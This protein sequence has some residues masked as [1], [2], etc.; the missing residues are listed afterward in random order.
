MMRQRRTRGPSASARFLVD[1]THAFIR[2]FVCLSATYAASLRVAM[3][4]RCEVERK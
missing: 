4:Q 2:L 1:H 3:G